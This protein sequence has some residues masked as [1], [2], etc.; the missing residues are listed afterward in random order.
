MP[1]AKGKIRNNDSVFTLKFPFFYHG[2]FEF[3]KIVIILNTVFWGCL[4]KICTPFAPLVALGEQLPEAS[5]HER[6]EV[7]ISG[8]P[9]DWPVQPRYHLY[10]IRDLI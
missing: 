4:I 1:E 6:M 5:Y 7:A 3:F 10:C 8:D 9:L 2:N